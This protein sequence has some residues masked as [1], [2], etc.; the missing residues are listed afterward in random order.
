MTAGMLAN[1]QNM[2]WRTKEGVQE[3]N[4]YG[5]LTQASTVF[6]GTME[7]RP[8]YVPLKSLVPMISPDDVVT[9]STR[10]CSY[11]SV[12]RTSSSTFA[13]LADQ[14]CSY[15]WCILIRVF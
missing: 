15:H 6:M 13:I 1:K 2:T 5:S 14:F 11:Y 10:A 12:S 3:A 7:G 9:E 4:W 8:V